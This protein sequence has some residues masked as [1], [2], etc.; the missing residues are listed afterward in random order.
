MTTTVTLADLPGLVGADLGHTAYRTVTQEQINLFADATDYHQWIHVDVERA[1]RGPFGAPI[2]HGYLTLSLLIPF[3]EELLQVEGVATKVNY[4]LDRVRFP[5]PVV[6]G[7]RI[8]MG[9]RIQD[10]SEA[11]GGVQL[12]LDS[13]IEAADAPK[14]SVVATTLFRYYA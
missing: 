1:Q 13:V 14:P 11:G 12:T 9:S 2:A 6:A 7:A 10:V 3:S 5:S 8:R 4:G